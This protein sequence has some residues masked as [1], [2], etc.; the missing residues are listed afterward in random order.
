MA[1]PLAMEAG[2]SGTGRI[3]RLSLKPIRLEPATS[4]LSRA[5]SDYQVVEG[6]I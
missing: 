1:R 6:R 2:K 4:G 3:F 5:G